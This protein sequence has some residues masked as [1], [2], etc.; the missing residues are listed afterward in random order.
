M[1]KEVAE[2]LQDNFGVP[3]DE[4]VY[5]N[6]TFNIEE[7]FVAINHMNEWEQKKLQIDNYME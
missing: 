7:Y 3:N 4:I 1:E 2:Y 6:P 5:F